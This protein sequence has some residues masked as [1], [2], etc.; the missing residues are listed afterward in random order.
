MCPVGDPVPG[1]L[2]PG[3]RETVTDEN[4]HLPLTWPPCVLEVFGMVFFL[5]VSPSRI[6]F[7]ISGVPKVREQ[8]YKVGG[9]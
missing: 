7:L 3:P 5:G 6:V 8:L 2:S 4:Q 1:D 9:R